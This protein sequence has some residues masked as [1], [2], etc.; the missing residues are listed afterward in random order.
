[1]R[2]DFKNKVIEH[3]D[4]L[5]VLPGNNLDN[6]KLV[7][8]DDRNNLLNKITLTDK[9][10]ALKISDELNG[11]KTSF[12]LLNDDAQVD[13]L[14]YGNGALFAYDLFTGKLL[15]YVNELADFND[16]QLIQTSDHDL[17]LAYDRNGDKIDVISTSGKLSLSIPDVTQK[18]MAC[19][20][21][22][23]GKTYVLLTN[24]NM[25]SCRELQ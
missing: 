13:L 20:L 19:E 25:I 21:Y 15:E 24:G 1:G 9:K 10:E 12:G 14:I 18:P 16:A 6:T 8:V 17:I 5:L 3:L 22:K 2:I 11:F 23:N 7:Y 4:H